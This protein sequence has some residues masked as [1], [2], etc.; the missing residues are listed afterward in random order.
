MW[1]GMDM[2][3]NNLIKVTSAAKRAGVK[4]Q[5]IYYRIEKGDLKAIP[6]DG[7]IYVDKDEAA[8]LKFRKRKSASAN[9]GGVREMFG[10]I[11]LGHATGSDNEAIDRDLAT[12]YENTHEA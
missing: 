2:K 4:R 11:S 7:S 6:I 8:K 10:S 1:H 9:P 12:E 5:A 3:T